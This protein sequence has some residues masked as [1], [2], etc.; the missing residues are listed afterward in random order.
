MSPVFI[1]Q[2]AFS[3]QQT[4][5]ALRVSESTVRRWIRKGTLRA[6]RAGPKLWRVHRS[7]LARFRAAR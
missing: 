7:E 5:A 2:E 4:A 1:K 6:F 3:I